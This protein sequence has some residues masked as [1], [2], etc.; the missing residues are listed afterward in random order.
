MYT[1][2]TLQSCIATRSYYI[3]SVTKPT[4]STFIPNIMIVTANCHLTRIQQYLQY[5]IWILKSWLE[6]PIRY[7][8]GCKVIIP[9][10]NDEENQLL[11][12]DEDSLTSLIGVA[13]ANC[14]ST[15][16]QQYLWHI[17]WILKSWLEYSTGYDND[18][19]LAISF[20]H[21]EENQPLTNDEDYLTLIGVVK[22]AVNTSAG[23]SGFC[24]SISPAWHA[25]RSNV[26]LNGSSNLI[27]PGAAS[28]SNNNIYELSFVISFLQ[29]I[30]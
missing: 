2:D 4:L 18:Y 5:M 24:G 26:S 20:T 25:A 8:N 17:M 7:D 13:T 6:Y 16:N 10:T 19:K 1:S 29:Y 21:D 28:C 9:S 14:H 3:S 15:K 11:T 22:Q 27:P 23:S 30:E 12:N